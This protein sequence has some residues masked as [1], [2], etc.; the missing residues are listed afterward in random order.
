[1]SQQKDK[2][3][4]ETKPATG[5]IKVSLWCLTWWTASINWHTACYQSIFRS[6]TQSVQKTLALLEQWMSKATGLMSRPKPSSLL[7]SLAWRWGGHTACSL[8]TVCWFTLW[9][10]ACPSSVLMLSLLGSELSLMDGM[11]HL[12]SQGN[13]FVSPMSTMP[14]LGPGTNTTQPSLDI[15]S[16][17]CSVL[18]I[19]SFVLNVK[20]LTS[21]AVSVLHLMLAEFFC[22]GN[23]RGSGDSRELWPSYGR[24]DGA[25]L[26][27]WNGWLVTSFFVHCPIGSCSLVWKPCMRSF[28][29]DLGMT[30]VTSLSTWTASWLFWRPCCLLSCSI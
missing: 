22:R 20:A 23:R 6:V 14:M 1:M 4:T 12:W 8:V 28:M 19:Y 18:G 24:K 11:P 21:G 26:S 15:L 27:S 2:Q 7:V 17:P 5:R 16:V 9:C 13:L 29:T 10:C 3:L 30:S 25:R